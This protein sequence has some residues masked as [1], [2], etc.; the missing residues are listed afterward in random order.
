MQK[1]TVL[2]TKKIG[3]HSDL[4]ALTPNVCMGPLCS[5]Q[6]DSVSKNN[7]I[8]REI[9]TLSL[10]THLTNYLVLNSHK[11][12][13]KYLQVKTCQPQYMFC[14]LRNEDEV[15]RKYHDKKNVP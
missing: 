15:W 2:E 14:L 4:I 3:V 12:I 1:K 13:T 8:T 10:P 9:L 11:L 5:E 6:T 7:I